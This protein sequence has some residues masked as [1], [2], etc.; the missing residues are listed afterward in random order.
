VS[1]N[2]DV[3][4]PSEVRLDAV[5]PAANVLP[6]KLLA[7]CVCVSLPTV[8]ANDISPDPSH[9]PDIPVTSPVRVIVLPVVHAA[10]VVAVLAL[11]VKAAVI[12]PAEKLPDA[13]L[14]TIVSAVFALVAL[15]VTLNVDPPV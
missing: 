5:T 2:N 11:P 8:A 4:V 10:A 7:S 14:A 6:V 9:P 1:A 12:V 13:S 15:D 3:I